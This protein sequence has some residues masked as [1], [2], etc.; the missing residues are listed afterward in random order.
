MIDVF[1]PKRIYPEGLFK[2]N[3]R[4]VKISIF[5][6]LCAIY[7]RGMLHRISAVGCTRR[8]S[9]RYD[10]HH[11]DNFVIEY[12]GEIGTKFENTL[13]CIS[14]A[15]MGS[16]HEKTGGRKSRDTLPLIKC[17]S[18]GSRFS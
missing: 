7:L 9:P 12:L 1:T 13:A 8:S 4:Q 17:V 11:G 14:E 16:N 18:I 10:A 3:N 6:S 5:F 15:Q 2:S